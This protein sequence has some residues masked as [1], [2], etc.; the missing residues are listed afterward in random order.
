MST[1]LSGIPDADDPDDEA[2]FLDP[3]DVTETGSVGVDEYADMD[4]ETGVSSATPRLAGDD[5][6]E[7]DEA[8]VEKNDYLS[9]D[10]SVQMGDDAVGWSY[11]FGADEEPERFVSWQTTE[12]REPTIEDTIQLLSDTTPS[13]RVLEPEDR[14]EA[15]LV[16]AVEELLDAKRRID[17]GLLDDAETVYAATRAL[18]RMKAMADEMVHWTARDAYDDTPAESLRPADLLNLHRLVEYLETMGYDEDADAFRDRVEAVFERVT[19]PESLADDLRESMPDSLTYEEA[20]EYFVES[21]EALLEG[22]RSVD[23]PGEPVDPAELVEDNHREFVYLNWEGLRSSDPGSLLTD[24]S[25]HQVTGE[26]GS[27]FGTTSDS[28][29]FGRSGA[30]EF[31]DYIT[32]GFQEYP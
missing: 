4:E 25:D 15:D 24:P 7:G 6:P 18:D 20:R 14:A 3:E 10:V 27:A 1:S 32:R 13:T 5:Y 16:D 11:L 19:I 17:I 22:D 2:E 30:D 28:L 12:E 21:E 31:A 23:W 29:A 8:A 9:V 26:G